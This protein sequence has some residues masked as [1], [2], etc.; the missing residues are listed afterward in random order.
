MSD[1]TTSLTA[2]LERAIGNVIDSI[3]ID[4]L[5]ALKIIQR[6]LTKHLPDT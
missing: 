1:I 3:A 2:A 5:K 6:K 4:G